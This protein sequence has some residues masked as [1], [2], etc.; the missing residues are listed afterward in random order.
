MPISRTTGSL[1]LGCKELQKLV[2][3]FPACSTT[4]LLAALEIRCRY[5]PHPLVEDRVTAMKNNDAC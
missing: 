2:S 5:Y 3:Q 4:I 1:F